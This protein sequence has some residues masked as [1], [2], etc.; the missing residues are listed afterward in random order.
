MDIKTK[1]FIDKVIAKNHANHKD[2]KGG[3]LYTYLK[4]LYV[5][6]KVPL[7]ITCKLHG[8][9]KQTPDKHLLGRG[10][11]GCKG[12]VGSNTGDFIKKAIKV[13]G[14]KYTYKN[15]VYTNSKSNITITCR[16]HG[17]FR[18]TPNKHLQNSGCPSCGSVARGKK[19]RLTSDQFIS[20]ANLKHKGWYTYNKVTYIST[21]FKVTITCPTHG[22]FDQ[23][24]SYH[25]S[26]NGCPTCALEI[27]GYT[28]THFKKQ[29][30][31][32]N[33]G[34]GTLYVIRCFNN[35]ESFYKIGRTSRSVKLRYR[36]KIEMPYNYEII[37]EFVFDADTIYDLEH[38]IFR[39]LVDYKYEPLISFGGQTECFSSIDYLESYFEYLSELQ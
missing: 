26:G 34:F 16:I 30:I 7:T 5:S 29:C 9:F 21:N 32:N 10:C 36:C 14:K 4:S 18:Q 13:H 27:S 37:H 3:W 24:P 22:D 12:G 17:D 23:M 28:K 25:L 19:R 38:D 20:A 31:K 1:T 11:K 15:S 6:A 35:K 33:K 8:D 39:N 2:V